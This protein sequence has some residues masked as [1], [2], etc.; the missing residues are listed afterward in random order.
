M[1]EREG[2]RAKIVADL[3]D[4]HID[5]RIDGSAEGRR[6]LLEIIRAEF[7][8]IHATFPNRL[9]ATEWVP[10]PGHETE[11]LE[12]ETLLKAEA[13]GETTFF[14][15][16]RGKVPL[17]ELLDGIADMSER[18]ADRV[19]SDRERTG[20]PRVD[21]SELIHS[22][23]SAIVWETKWWWVVTLGMAAGVGLLAVAIW[24]F[25]A[26]W[27]R[28]F[29]GVFAV[30]AAFMFARNPRY[31]YQRMAATTFLAMLGSN[32]LGFALNARLSAP[33]VEAHLKW[34]A[35]TSGVFTVSCMIIVVVLLVLDFLHQRRR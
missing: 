32:A 8:S 27:V 6:R 1:L 29:F 34:D 35:Q 17:A 7:E 2:N 21:R 15:K 5:I 28:I 19:M 20:K 23:R 18:F 31:Q 10:V 12:Y 13:A 22:V 30:V 14:T 3:E 33:G 4:G 25:E 16:S 24:Y 11:L 9:N 26:L